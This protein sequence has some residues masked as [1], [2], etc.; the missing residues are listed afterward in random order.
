MSNIP[1][2]PLLMPMWRYENMPHIGS[3]ILKEGPL[4]AFRYSEPTD[5]VKFK[6]NGKLKEIYYV[7]LYVSLYDAGRFVD[8][9]QV[10][11]VGG[12]PE[13]AIAI[14]RDMIER[15]AAQSIKDASK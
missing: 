1:Y 5:R 3:L 7:K 2:N 12:F 15:N 6:E 14:A 10:R 8:Q 11:I 13:D 9:K 4:E